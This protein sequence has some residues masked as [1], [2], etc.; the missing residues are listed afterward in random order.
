MSQRSARPGSP[1][2][3]CLFP[4]LIGLEH[5]SV[6]DFLDRLD[7]LCPEGGMYP[8]ETSPATR[9]RIPDLL[10]LPLPMGHFC[11]FHKSLLHA[12]ATE[13]KNEMTVPFLARPALPACY[14]ITQHMASIM[15]RSPSKISQASDERGDV[16]TPPPTINIPAQRQLGTQ[17]RQICKCHANLFHSYDAY[18]T[19]T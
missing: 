18:T 3:T 10:N 6:E 14:L 7:L 9:M 16:D 5:S 4:Y 12:V 19:G 1:T 13:I 11:N 2:P 17:S 15:Q 8:C